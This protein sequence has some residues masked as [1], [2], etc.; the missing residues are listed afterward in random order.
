MLGYTEAGCDTT[1][2]R[3]LFLQFKDLESRV[4]FFKKRPILREL[5]EDLT[6]IQIEHCK[7]CMPRVMQACKEGHGAFY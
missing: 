2:K 6:K 4:T 7:T 5:D 1:R 3:A